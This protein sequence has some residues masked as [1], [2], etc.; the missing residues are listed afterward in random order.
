LN[1]GKK[2][3]T[4]LAFAA[5]VMLAATCFSLI[6]PSVEYAGG[7]MGGAFIALVGILVGGNFLI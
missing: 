6:V 1:E 4:M 3:D 5:E 7:G 2:I